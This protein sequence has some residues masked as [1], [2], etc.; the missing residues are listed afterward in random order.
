MDEM[1]KKKK[2]MAM[3]LSGL[4]GLGLAVGGATFALFSST[5][6]NNNNQFMA[7]TLHI[8]SNR[9]DVPTVGPMFYTENSTNTP[10][11]NPTSVWAPG[12]KNTRGL[13]LKND[14]T[15]PAKLKSISISDVSGSTHVINM[16]F[17][18]KAKVIIWQVKWFNS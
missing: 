17:A 3:S 10:G 5:A 18:Q 6:S 14:G 1:N 7:G 12:D 13:F 2:L 16:K 11:I 15:L 8:S 4:L 9:D